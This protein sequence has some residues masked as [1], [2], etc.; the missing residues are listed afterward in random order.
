MVNPLMFYA[1]KN[2]VKVTVPAARAGIEVGFD[3][4]NTDGDTKLSK[5]EDTVAN[6]IGKFFKTLDTYNMAGDPDFDERS[7]LNAPDDPSYT[8]P[9]GTTPTPAV[10]L[11]DEKLD[12]WELNKVYPMWQ[13]NHLLE[14]YGP[15]A[16]RNFLNYSYLDILALARSMNSKYVTTDTT[17]NTCSKMDLSTNIP[18]DVTSCGSRK[19]CVNN[20]N[21]SNTFESCANIIW[22]EGDGTVK[23][24]S[25]CVPS[26]YCGMNVDN[27]DT[28]YWGLKT[29]AGQVRCPTKKPDLSAATKPE[30]VIPPELK[31]LNAGYKCKS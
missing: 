8:Y 15:D 6:M 12:R 25:K 5:K 10:V 13:V 26:V 1:M 7:A 2:K 28:L 18:K 19:P 22:N 11:P 3:A 20:V 9:A 29:L 27:K 30:V 4:S 21:C 17:I 14:S 16:L 31:L 24:S 23:A